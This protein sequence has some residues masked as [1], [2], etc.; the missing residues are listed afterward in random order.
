[1]LLTLLLQKIVKLAPFF[2]SSSS[3]LPSF[4]PSSLTLP[5][6]SPFLSPSSLPPTLL[7]LCRAS[8]GG[9]WELDAGEC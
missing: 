3:L 7:P 4:P 9:Y 8:G 2:L 6:L 5:P 1:M